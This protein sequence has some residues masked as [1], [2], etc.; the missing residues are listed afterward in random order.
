MYSV[1][2]TPIPNDSVAHNESHMIFVCG[3]SC[4]CS[5]VFSFSYRICPCIHLFDTERP[6]TLTTAIL[7]GVADGLR[8]A[9]LG[10]PPTAVFAD[11]PPFGCSEAF[12][13]L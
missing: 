2:P 9:I 3:A 4:V 13:V 11:E 1:K 12:A 7:F 5:L 8:A 10:N 6:A